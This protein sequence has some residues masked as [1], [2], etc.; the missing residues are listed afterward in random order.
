MDHVEGTDRDDV[1]HIKK[2]RALCRI[3]LDE[4][5]GEIVTGG[6]YI[7]MGSS[8]TMPPRR[9]YAIPC[10][11]PG[12]TEHKQKILARNGYVRT[13]CDELGQ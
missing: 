11:M 7:S 6:K 10:V 2:G 12:W 9:R 5:L 4:M 1:E 8:E 13:I 3:R